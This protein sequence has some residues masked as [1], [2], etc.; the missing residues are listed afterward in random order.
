[1]KVVV[2]FGGASLA[3]GRRVERAANAVAE[4]VETGHQVAVVAS[5]MGDATDELLD[6]LCPDAS[7]TDRAEVL[8]MGER[9]SVRMLKSYLSARGVNATVVEPGDD[10]WPIFVRPGEG[11]AVAIEETRA[12]TERLA[13][14]LAESVPVVTGFLA[15]DDA[16]NVRTLGRGGSDTTAMI[17]G[18][19]AGADRVVLVTD[20]RG[21]L[22]GDPDAIDEGS[23]LDEVPVEEAREL[24]VRG[25]E[26]VTPTALEYKTEA[27]ELGVV[28][29]EHDDLLSD[30]T[31]VYGEL[32]TIVS[33]SDAPFAGITVSG[34][35]SESKTP[36]CEDLVETLSAADASVENLFVDVNSVTCYVRRDD[37]RDAIAVVHELVER[38]EHLSS[39][40]TV[41]TVAAAHVDAVDRGAASDDVREL[42]VSLFDSTLKVF[43]VEM[44]ANSMTAYLNWDDRHTARDLLRTAT[45]R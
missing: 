45:S 13:D 1:M 15:E 22:T 24:A 26:V 9:T 25:A 3:T 20:V 5:A 17:L 27:V 37:L 7:A 10:D 32:D 18:R 33:F 35:V 30:G 41:E 29:Y 12:K 40:S 16:G 8:S 4:L 36:I 14:R 43:D 44:T 39:C 23:R 19:F 28:H 2:K 11:N 42:A 6:G 38:H 31:D 21:I 34:A